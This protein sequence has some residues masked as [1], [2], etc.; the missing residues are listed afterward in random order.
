MMLTQRACVTLM[1]AVSRVSV[2]KKN[3][4]TLKKA[5]LSTFKMAIGR[6]LGGRARG[7]E[8]ALF[9]TYLHA[10]FY[11]HASFA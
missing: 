10:I 3:K 7:L 11:V 8:K 1:T 4:T 5:K 6:N 2:K 9:S